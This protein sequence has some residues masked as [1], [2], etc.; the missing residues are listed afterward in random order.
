MDDRLLALTMARSVARKHDWMESP[1]PDN[2]DCAQS[3]WC[4]GANRGP[5]NRR[6]SWFN[7]RSASKNAKNAQRGRNRPGDNAAALRAS[8]L[9]G[10]AMLWC[11]RKLVTPLECALTKNAP[12]TPLE[13][14][15]TILLHLK[16][17]GM[18]TCKKA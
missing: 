9:S 5:M 1:M 10:G 13:S 17:F 6:I 8:W 15:L 2:A 12:A 3:T 14:A 4:W 11:S 16:P 18:N 7:P